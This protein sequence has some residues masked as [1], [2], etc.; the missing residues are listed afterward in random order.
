MLR[1]NLFGTFSLAD[2]GGV[3]IPVKSRKARAL[4]AYLA[5]SPGLSRSREEVMALLWSERGET[6][7]R[8]SLRQVLTGLRKDLGGALISDNDRVALVPEKIALAESNGQ[9]LLA[10]FHLNDPAFEE[11]LRDERLRLEDDAPASAEVRTPEKPDIAVLPFD[12][13]SEVPGQEVFSDGVTE[14]IITELSRFSA[15]TVYSPW[16]SFHFDDNKTTEEIAQELEVD[17]VLEGSVRRLGD[18]ARITAMLFDAETCNHV[19]VQRYDRDLGDVFAVQEEVAQEITTAVSGKIEADAYDEAVQRP[20]RDLSAYDLVLLGERAQHEEWTAPD[21]VT[22]YEKAIAADPECARAWANLA[23][24]HACS[25]VTH[26]VP[27]DEARRKTREL[28]ETALN[29]APNDAIV[30]AIMAD[31]YA[32]V[33]DTTLS[34]QCLDKAIRLNPNH[35]SVIIFAANTLAWLGDVDAA[36]EWLERYLRHDPLWAAEAM[37]VCLEVYYVAGRY[38]EAVAAIARWS[39]LPLHVLAASAAA[40]AQC[41]RLEEAAAL[42]KL[43]EEGLP[44]GRSFEAHIVAPTRLCPNP[45]LVERWLEGFRKAGFTF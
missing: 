24:W 36:Q 31:A 30:L 19:W 40:H 5:L 10:G 1:L 2:S 34:R 6:Q 43:Y 16:S 35:H 22:Y 27:L 37:E 28:G 8:G 15:F 3:D 18:R 21:A 12:T 32:G 38:E 42:R 44:E 29:I 23:D 26:F 20:A 4:L 17:Y 45:E 7:A 13:L 14:D 25:S 33:G 39:D 9:E 41:G 11:W